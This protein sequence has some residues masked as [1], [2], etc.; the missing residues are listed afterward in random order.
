MGR[1]LA[2]RACRPARGGGARSSRLLAVS[3]S[4]LRQAPTFRDQGDFFF[5][6]KLYTADRHPPRGAAALEPALRGGEP[7]LANLQSGVFYPPG[8]LFLLPSPALAAGPLP[9]LP[10]RRRGVSGC[11]RFCKEEG[12]SD[13]RGA[14][15]IRRL[16]RLRASRRRSPATGTTSAP[17]RWLPALAALARSGLRTA[18][19]RLAF[20]GLFALQA[21]S[22]SPEISAATLAISRFCSPGGL[23][24]RQPRRRRLPAAPVPP[25]PT[26]GRRGGSRRS[27]SRPRRSR[28]SSSSPRRP[29]AGGRFPSRKGSRARV[30]WDRALFGGRQVARQRA[31]RP[32]SPSLA[33]GTLALVLAGGRV[34]GARSA[35]RSSCC[36]AGDRRGRASCSRPRA[37]PGPG[38]ARFRR[39]TGSGIRR[40]RSR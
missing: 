28:L 35:A 9:A 36:S 5:P 1:A 37:R 29:T 14:R 13:E 31:A 26:A 39:S 7:W 3:G 19:D 22:G 2:P 32:I 6:L 16:R 12:V 27:C 11:A 30:G 34:R 33:A 17:S 10:L 21:L 20:A 18:G 23:E 4:A 24:V 8:L 25:P 40:R 38:C 15:R